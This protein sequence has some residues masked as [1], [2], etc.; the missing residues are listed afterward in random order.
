MATAQVSDDNDN[1]QTEELE[2][3]PAS[4]KSKV[5]QYFVFPMSY[6]SPNASLAKRLPFVCLSKAYAPLSAV[7][8]LRQHDKYGNAYTQ[9]SQRNRSVR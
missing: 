1:K 3:P 8:H 9:A 5:W 7:S 4:F 6:E 2:N